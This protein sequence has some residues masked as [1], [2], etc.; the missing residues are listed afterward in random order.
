VVGP[1]TW[2]SSLLISALS[3]LVNRYGRVDLLLL[4]ELGYLQLDRRGAELLWLSSG[5][6]GC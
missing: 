3:R 5:F 2:R 1:W 6:C 4:D